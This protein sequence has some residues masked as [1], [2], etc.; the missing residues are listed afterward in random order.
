M[1][2]RD[3][4]SACQI[5]PET[6]DMWSVESNG[7]VSSLEERQR[8][9]F[10]C[11]TPLGGHEPTLVT[12]LSSALSSNA[13]TGGGARFVM[14]ENGSEFSVKKAIDEAVKQEELDEASFKASAFGALAEGY[15]KTE[16]ESLNRRFSFQNASSTACG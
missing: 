15:A 4:F 13:S 2:T 8:I 16:A 3:Y 12:M 10:M 1:I 11:S 6:T 14:L 7:V 9:G 5:H